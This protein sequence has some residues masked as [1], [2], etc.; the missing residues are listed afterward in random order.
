MHRLNG[1]DDG[2]LHLESATAP[3]NSMAIGVLVPATGPDGEPQ[4]ITM[5]DVRRHMAARLGDMPSLRWRLQPVPLRLNHP[6]VIE[7]PDF[8]LDY[9]LRHEVLP[10]PGGPA[11]LD[12]LVADLGE[13]HFDRRH[14]LWQ[15]TLV[16]GLAG[17]RQAAIYRVQHALQDGTAAYTSFSLVFSGADRVATVPPG[18][19]RPDPV[20]TRRR[21]VADALRDLAGNLAHLPQLAVKT[22]AGMTALKAH[23]AT[24]TVKAPEFVVDTPPTSFNDAFT[25]GHTYARTALPLD[26][27]KLVKNAAGVSLNDVLLGAVAAGARRYLLARDDLPE[28]PLTASVPVGF[29]PAD[30]PP[31]QYGN[32]FTNITTSLATD[33]ADPWDRLL[34]ISAVTSEAKACLDISGP[35][36]MADWL[37]M[38]PPFI[39]EPGIHSLQKRRNEHREEAEQSIVVSNIKGPS[40]LWHFD[41]AL[42]ESLHIQGPPSNGVGPNVMVW[43]YGDQLLVGVLAFED[44][45]AD[46]AEF[47][48]YIDDGLAE[49]VDRARAHAAAPSAG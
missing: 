23:Q 18:Q 48:S 5:A 13:R 16:D 35:E 47:C 30:A 41:T 28:R 38:V 17:G 15:L 49:L 12:R 34:Q 46:P 20:P 36:M 26:D 29:E 33:I 32:R 24:A 43:S 45:M 8:D 4:L 40:E 19:W 6:V 7:D 10:A 27:V 39:A 31:R 14:P 9:H 2:F 22:R 11:Q 25:L 44:A 1:L 37:D 3:M 42:V 21:L